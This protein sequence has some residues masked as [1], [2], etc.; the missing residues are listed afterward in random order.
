MTIT[1]VVN[2]CIQ[3]RVITIITGTKQNNK[4]VVVFLQKFFRTFLSVL[5]LT[6]HQYLPQHLFRIEY[7][8]KK[9]IIINLS[10]FSKFEN[11]RFY[12]K[13]KRPFDH[14][15]SL[16]TLIKYQ[17]IKC[18]LRS[19]QICF[20]KLMEKCPY[21]ISFFFCEVYLI[22]KCGRFQ[23]NLK[24]SCKLLFKLLARS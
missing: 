22:K 12:V 4:Y 3:Y 6:E 21:I 23:F 15:Q 10:Y 8:S 14:T 9:K 20:S 13:M 7:F 1:A 2:N 11:Q 5:K 24:F 18:G 16:N 17:Y 19:I